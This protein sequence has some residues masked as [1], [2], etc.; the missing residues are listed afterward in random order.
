MKEFS[1][2]EAEAG[3]RL[4]RF[5][6]R[7][8]GPMGQGVI[9][10]ALRSGQVRI[11]G[12]KAKSGHRL[13]AD[14]VVS[15]APYFLS[16]AERQEGVPA[17]PKKPV[18]NSENAAKQIEQMTLKQTSEWRA[19][20]KPSGLAVQGGTQTHKHVDGLLNAGF[21]SR[22]YKLVHRIDKDTSGVLLVADGHHAARNLTAA[23]RNHSIQKFYLALVVGRLPASGVISAG[24]RKSGGKGLEKMIVDDS[25]GQQAITD[26]ICFDSAG[27]VSLVGFSP[28]TGRTHQLRAHAAHLGTPILGDGKYGGAAA[29]IGGFDKKLHLHAWGL[30]LP[31]GVEIFA[32]LPVHLSSSVQM[33]GL[34]LPAATNFP[35]FGFAGQD[36]VI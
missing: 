33:A 22:E 21:P 8:A 4:D 34:R 6:R 28:R 32:P 36:R 35:C 12:Q 26:F 9:E 31:E 17:Q 14:Q 16:F 13:V 7:V 23:F 2:T 10:K 29:H 15:V 24:L 30:K 1:V 20:N 18:M 11:D 5:L 19:L 27:V 25:E 3:V